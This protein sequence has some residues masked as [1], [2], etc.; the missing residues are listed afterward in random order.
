ML[1]EHVRSLIGLQ[2]YIWGVPLTL[3]DDASY[4]RQTVN[5][6]DPLRNAATCRW[7][8][9]LHL[10]NFT[11]RHVPGTKHQLP[12]ALSRLDRDSDDTAAE[13]VEG[14]ITEHVSFLSTSTSLSFLRDEPEAMPTWRV[15]LEEHL[16]DGQWLQLG[17]YFENL[18]RPESSTNDEYK[19][20]KRKAHRYFDRNGKL[21]KKRK[22]GALEVEVVIQTETKAPSRSI[23]RWTWGMV[24]QARPTD[25]SW[26][27]HGGLSSMKTSSTGSRVVSVR[28][29]RQNK[30]RRNE[31]QPERVACWN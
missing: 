21:W 9:W 23:T 10:L 8:A 18:Q 25:V 22:N 26:S 19:R 15:Y 4:L 2:L 14:F 1:D 20:V 5:S 13:S 7:V 28:S 31:S 29:A 11:I 24:A 17:H 6:P 12:D 16:S 3:K 30:N 27:V